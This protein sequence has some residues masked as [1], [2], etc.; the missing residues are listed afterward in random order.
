MQTMSDLP[1]PH[2]ASTVRI[3]ERDSH[4]PARNRQETDI[5]VATKD[6][7]YLYDAEG[8]TLI[9]VGEEDIRAYTGKQDFC[10][11]RAGQSDLCGGFHKIAGTG[12]E[13]KQFYAGVIPVSSA[14]MFI[15]IAH[16]PAL[17]PWF[18]GM[19]ISRPSEKNGA[20]PGQKSHPVSKCGISSCKSVMPRHG[21]AATCEPA[22]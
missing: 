22:R 16:P 10:K 15:F 14:R 3:P 13:E 17:P 7:L 19:W 12:T 20:W 18:G 2:G 21:K 11:N 6:A 4:R 1:G 5:Y 9:A 8:H